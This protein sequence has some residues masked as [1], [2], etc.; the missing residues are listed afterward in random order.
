MKNYLRFALVAIM[1][2]VLF[3]ACGSS[4]KAKTPEQA[5]AA[6]L[7]V[8][9][10]KDECEKLVLQ[11]GKNWRASGIGK[12]RDKAFAESS[13]QITAKANLARRMEEHTV[14][15]ITVFRGQYRVDDYQGVDGKDIERISGYADQLVRGAK[16]ICTNSYAKEDGSYQYFVCMEMGEEILSHLYKKLTDDQKL[17]IDFEEHQFKQEMEKMKEDYR[18]R[19][20]Q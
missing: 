19:Q 20:Q 13:A 11:E 3:S 12:S 16:P 15:A 7:G 10:E 8:K 4:N 5:A 6:D 17:S 18:N 9:M 2:G 1:A 14:A